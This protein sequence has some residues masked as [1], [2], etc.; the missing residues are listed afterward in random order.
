MESWLTAR[1]RGRQRRRRADCARKKPADRLLD[2]PR[3][4]FADIDFACAIEID[5]IPRM[6]CFDTR[7]GGG[8]GNR[9]DLGERD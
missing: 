6:S 9:Q 8:D 5:A 1:E 4:E 2:S 7:G 3:D